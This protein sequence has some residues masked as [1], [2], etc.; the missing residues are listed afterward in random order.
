M[1]PRLPA[2]VNFNL[3]TANRNVHTVAQQLR[4][5]SLACSSASSAVPNASAFLQVLMATGRSALATTTGRPRK[6]NPSA[7]DHLINFLLC[8][9]ILAIS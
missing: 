3:Q 7:L 4:T 5:R 8:F 1:W 6:E 2:A 9:P